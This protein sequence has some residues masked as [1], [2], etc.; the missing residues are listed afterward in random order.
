MIALCIAMP[1]SAQGEAGKADGK[2]SSRLAQLSAPAMASRSRA[3]VAVD[4]GLPASGAG[5]MQFSVGGAVL[6]SIRV[7]DVSA[8]T[9]AALVAAGATIR[10]VSERFGVIDAYVPPGSLDAVAAV[11]AVNYVGEALAPRH[12]SEQPVAASMAAR[13]TTAAATCPTGVLTEGDAQLKAAEARTT[14]SVTGS[15]VKVGVV[16]DS[17]DKEGSITT[18]QQDIE[19]GDLPGAD[20]PCGDTTPVQV[21]HEASD[22]A[23]LQSD[24]GRAMLQIVHDLAPDAGLAFAT[25]GGSMYEMADNIRDL[26]NAGMD[27]ITD[28]IVFYGEPFFQ[29]GPVNI[30]IRE[31]AAKGIPHFTAAG[32]ANQ[33][34]NAG[35]NITSYEASAYRPMAC[36]DFKMPDGSN[37]PATDKPKDCHN[38]NPGSGQDATSAFTAGASGMSPVMEFQWAEPWF[39][40]ATDLDIFII[41]TST[42]RIVV[43]SADSNGTQSGYTGTQSPVEITGWSGAAGKTYALIIGRYSGSGTPRIKYVFQSARG[44][45]STEY[46][47]SNNSVDTF[48][49]SVGDHVA[50]A[51]GIGVAAVP[52]NDSNTP[53]DYTSLGPSTHYF[54]PLTYAAGA[55][56]GV[57]LAHTPAAALATPQVLNKPDFAATDGG[58]TSFFGNANRFYGTSAAAPHA[59]GVAA[60][61]KEYTDTHG[62]PFNS[63]AVEVLM[64]AS[65]SPIANGTAADTGAGLLNAVKAIQVMISLEPRAYMP[66]IAR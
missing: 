3:Q 35:N 39:G 58:K 47:A 42:N 54:G 50:V 59:A 1:V 24:E 51:E 8:S 23:S 48:G 64:E 52:Y 22:N 45:A 27:I 15:G 62:K 29:D 41:D 2:L 10:H 37:I 31:N 13:R 16:S 32:N 21:V 25:A 20:N 7:S 63:S 49:P 4:L 36:P 43:K 30:A 9:Q 65:A 60:L 66:L 19:A 44:I 18:A 61:I 53:E 57:N 40:I 56:D 12:R 34:D 5:S 11:G 38:F 6:A 14:Y 17:Y 28:D 33:L 26:G 46:N 55:S